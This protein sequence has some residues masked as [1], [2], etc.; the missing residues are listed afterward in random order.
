MKAGDLENCVLCGQ[1]MMHAG[2]P[3]FWRIT[4][5]RMGVDMA[6][7]QREAGLE[8]MMGGHVALAR[9]MGPN[10]DIAAPIGAERTVLVCE[11]CSSRHTSIYELGL[12][13]D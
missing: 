13:D 10:E 12:V 6:A 2:M 11:R 9:I 8:M 3:L 5:Q 1:G 7:V 4:L